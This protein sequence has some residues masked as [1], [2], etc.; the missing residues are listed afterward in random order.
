M[1]KRNVLRHTVELNLEKTARGRGRERT[2]GHSLTLEVDGDV[3][4]QFSFEEGGDRGK[5]GARYADF[6]R[7]HLGRELETFSLL[8]GAEALSEAFLSW[9]AETG[10]ADLERRVNLEVSKMARMAAE[11][12]RQGWV[13]RVGVNRKL[14]GR[15][16]EWDRGRRAEARAVYDELW[17][18]VK[19]AKRTMAAN[20][21]RRDWRE[22]VKGAH[23]DVPDYVIDG[24]REHT[25]QP[26]ELAQRWAAES[27]GVD[28]N[29]YFER[30]LRLAKG[31]RQEK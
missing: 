15:R 4:A 13:K 5:M 24:L 18:K 2:V 10:D 16:A 21:R 12:T 7:E 6:L 1:P 9:S 31:E 20:R 27:L 30:M 17:A 28:L 19:E 3:V 14:G 8:M 23:P 25:H 11:I 22:L 26:R 29:S